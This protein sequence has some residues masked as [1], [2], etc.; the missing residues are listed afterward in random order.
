MAN[1]QV[2][3]QVSFGTPELSVGVLRPVGLVCDEDLS[4]CP[5]TQL[6][7]ICDSGELDVEALLR[8]TATVEVRDQGSDE[9]VR[10]V[11]GVI[12]H[13]S[14][15]AE[16]SGRSEGR[17]WASVTIESPLAC[18]RYSKDF[19]IHQEL[20]TREI[21]QLVLTQ[22]GLDA[23]L[24]E[25]RLIG[26]YP[27]REVCTQF[28]ESVLAFV[29]RILEEDG[30]TYFHEYAESGVTVV[31]CDSPEGWS[32]ATP[33]ELNYLPGTGLSSGVA[34]LEVSERARLRPTSITLRDHSFKHPSLDLDCTATAAGPLAREHYDYPGR[35]V[36]KGEGQ[37][38]AQARMAEVVASSSRIRAATNA[39][40]MAP[41]HVVQLNNTPEGTLDGEWVPVRVHHEWRQEDGAV[42][43][44]NQ[45]ELLP[46]SQAFRPERRTALARVPGVQTAVVTGPAGEEIYC[47]EYGRVKVQFHWDRYGKFD[48]KS[49]GWVRVGQMQTSG[50]VV[51]PRIG[52]EVLVD[53][54]DGDPDKPVI[55]G[56]L[57]NGAFP[58]P[59]NLPADNTI[60]ALTS[61]SSPGGGGHNEIRMNDAAG[62]ELVNVHAQKDLNLVVANNKEETITND[63]T[64]GVGVDETLSVGADQTVSVTSDDALTVGGS[65]Q[66]TV[67]A[68]RT[69]T[70]TGNQKLEVSGSRSVTIGASHTTMTPMADSTTTMGN[71]TETI[72]TM[73]LEAAAL[74]VD[75][76]VGG[77]AA[78][79]IGAA[80]IEAVAKGK[81]DTTVGARVS[82]IGGALVQIASE[83]IASTTSSSHSTLVGGAWLSNASGNSQFSTAETL[84]INVGG[85]LIVSGSSK[86]VF[87]VGDSNITL[88]SGGVVL[89]S[90]EVTL[91]ATALNAELA[92]MVGSK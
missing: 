72:G 16:R 90:K 26:K 49:S 67:G 6:D 8:Q 17:Q 86:V 33:A 21:V 28:N 58:P 25:W 18:L 39:F 37:R 89:K 27:K 69:K 38:R 53:F 71:L 62:S 59:G 61:F 66:W 1:T 29:S 78:M 83:D 32:V 3:Y 88:A 34:L 35:Y 44:L 46:K 43:Y 82:G 52:W 36:A 91:N 48:D 74:G 12:T 7:V 57:Y 5:K 4:G 81:S 70:V 42:R 73:C 75:I 79:T 40:G 76:T 64:L 65:Q 60:T 87:K 11:I 54:E 14:E 68:S 31:F 23:S 55:V 15:R 9:V 80:K 2:N 13:V 77:A 56:R 63:R 19:R 84:D 47:D 92:P 22:Y 41:G 50:S 10:R 45:T 30:I 24:L 51:I 85:A 20:T